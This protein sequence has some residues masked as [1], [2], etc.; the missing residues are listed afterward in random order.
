VICVVRCC[1]TRDEIQRIQMETEMEESAFGLA[2]GNT[3]V[4][5]R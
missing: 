4:G 2:A 3:Y 5:A 1:V